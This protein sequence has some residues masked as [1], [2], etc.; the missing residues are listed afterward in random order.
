[1]FEN[2]DESWL[3]KSTNYYTRD[4]NGIVTFFDTI[5]EAIAN[6]ISYEGYRLS[7]ETDEAIT[8]IRREELPMIPEYEKGSL[9]DMDISRRKQ[10]ESIVEVVRK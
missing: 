7:I 8:T 3:M 1:M 2:F 9:T 6:F 10:Y 4:Q 5:E